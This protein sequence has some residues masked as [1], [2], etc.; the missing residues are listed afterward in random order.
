MNGL[1]AAITRN[2]CPVAFASKAFTHTQS[3]YSNLEREC[4]AVV[5]EI[6]RFF[7]RP[8]IMVKALQSSPTISLWK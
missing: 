4:L 2:N 8:T 1:G 5:H 7:N 3:N 6:H